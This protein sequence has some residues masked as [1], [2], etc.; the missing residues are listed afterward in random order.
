MKLACLTSGS[1]LSITAR[2]TLTAQHKFVA[3]DEADVIVVLGGDGHLLHSIHDHLHLKKPFYG[4]NCGTVGFLLNEYRPDEVFERISSAI[5]LDLPLLRVE[6]E[7]TSEEKRSLLAFNEMSIVRYSGQSLNLG[8]SIDG[9]RQLDK[10]VGDGLIFATPAGSTAYNLAVRGPILPL[11]ANVLALTP[12]SPYRPRRWF[13][14]V[15][16]SSTRLEI[17]VLHPAKRP[18]GV[19]ADFIEVRDVKRV[20]AYLD[21]TVTVTIMFDERRSLHDRIV[22]EQFYEG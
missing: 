7:T 12:V 2:R 15:V 9:T 17:E 4:I 14:A 16:P 11:N 5:K 20:L 1:D 8:I 13:G 19:S 3:P 10:Y 22:S 21:D 18:A 6:T